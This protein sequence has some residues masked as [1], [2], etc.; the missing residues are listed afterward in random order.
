MVSTEIFANTRSS[1][2]NTEVPTELCKMCG[3]YEN[4]TYSR[5]II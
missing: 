4:G 3:K 1:I 5:K 2:R